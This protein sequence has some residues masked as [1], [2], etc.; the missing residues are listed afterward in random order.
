MPPQLVVVSESIRPL[1]ERRMRKRSS[2]WG[3]DQERALGHITHDLRAP[4]CAIM[5]YLDLATR[6]IDP[7]KAPRATEYLSLARQASQRM[8]QMVDDILEMFRVE[9]GQGLLQKKWVSVPFLFHNSRNTFAGLADLKSIHLSHTAPEDL[10]AWAD[11]RYLGRILD[12]LISNALK[13]TPSGGSIE[14][15]AKRHP[16]RVIFEVR[17]SGRGIPASFR[18]RIF[19]KF[20]Q[21]QA[22]DYQTGFG[23]GLAVSKA[24]AKAHGGNIRVESPAGHGSRFIFWIPD[25]P[26]AP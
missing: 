5:G 24:I 18:R 11:P 21:L 2:A 4:L 14:L 7:S 13:F 17:D 12:N 25:A 9:N 8:Q 23:L 22:S 26:V 10:C 20:P 3:S 1:H 6:M 16:G 19:Q 15:I